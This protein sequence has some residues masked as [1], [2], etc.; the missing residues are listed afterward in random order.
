MINIVTYSRP[1]DYYETLAE[2]Y[3]ALTTD[4]L[5][6]AAL[7]S[8]KGD[9]LVYVIVGDAEIVRPQLDA[10]GLPVEVREATGEEPV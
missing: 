4:Q 9:D 1:D 5:D 2:K 6:A 3:S 10:L 7:Q 8:F